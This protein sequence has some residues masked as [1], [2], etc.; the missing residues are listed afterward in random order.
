MYESVEQHKVIKRVTYKRMQ[1]LRIVTNCGGTF[2]D[3]ARKQVTDYYNRM[4]QNGNFIVQICEFD[5][6]GILCHHNRITSGTL[7]QFYIDEHPHH[8][9]DGEYV[10]LSCLVLS[11]LVFYQWWR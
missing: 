7:G 2:D 11:C 9:V 3:N 4:K 10:V 6:I 1:D 5:D 8:I